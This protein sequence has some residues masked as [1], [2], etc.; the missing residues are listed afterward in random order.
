MTITLYLFW[1]SKK[2]QISARTY[3]DLSIK[4]FQPFFIQHNE[5]TQKLEPKKSNQSPSKCLQIV[6]QHKNCPVIHFLWNEN[7]IASY[8]NF[9]SYSNVNLFCEIKDWFATPNFK[10]TYS[11]AR[12]FLKTWSFQSINDPRHVDS[13]E[14]WC[15]SNCFSLLVL[16]RNPSLLGKNE[17]PKSEL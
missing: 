10:Y 11:C 5:C 1:F 4:S 6:L 16:L 12:Y 8:S 7:Y 2:K 15:V 3:F 14:V 13:F 9:P 17:F